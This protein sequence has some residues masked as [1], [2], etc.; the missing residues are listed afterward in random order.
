MSRK[1]GYVEAE[2][3]R[4]MW[5]IGRRQIDRDW[6]GGTDGKCEDVREGEE[7]VD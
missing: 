2:E 4:R 3:D 7:K 6:R 1:T 5:K